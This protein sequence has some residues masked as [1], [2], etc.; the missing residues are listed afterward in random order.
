[1]IPSFY[2]RHVD[3]TL[4]KMPN[5]ESAT[6][7][8][9]VLNRVHPS[10]SFTMELEHEGSIPFLGTVITRCGNT[11]KTEV[12]RKPTDTGLL[13]HF[14]S[15]VDNRYK[16]GLVN[17]MVDRAYRLSST[18]EGFTKEC[19]KLRTTFSK[20]H[21][22]STLVNSTIRRFMQETDRALHVVTSSEPSVYIELPFKDQRSADRVLKEIS[23]LGSM[24]NAN[25]KPIFT[26]RKLSQT[27]SVKENKL[28][29][30]NKQ[31][32]LYSFQCDLCD[33]NY[34]GF[35]ARHLH[36]RI[37]D[38]ATGKHLETQHDNK[39]AKI[40]HVFKV[41]KKCRS[42]F[43]CLIYEMLFIKDIKPSLNTQSDS[44]RTKLFT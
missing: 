19:D 9:Q 16:K 4:V 1:M 44:M 38:S 11:L 2:G 17:T 18:E 27:L 28:P 21:Y 30:V 36:Q 14:Q 15:Y 10:L 26:S 12:Y 24:I 39:R 31:C 7:F 32:V 37:S 13:L 35:T 5:A 25:V 42:K 29:I 43:D 40:D 6:D 34:V 33:A 8:L 41:L 23:Y 3:D 22:P 20:L